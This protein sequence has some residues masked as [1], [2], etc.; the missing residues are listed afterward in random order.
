M[1]R[2]TLSLRQDAQRSR[3]SNAVN[4]SDRQSRSHSIHGQCDGNFV[5]IRCCCS[6]KINHRKILY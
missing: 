1:V 4:E 5:T 3:S 6:I 2:L